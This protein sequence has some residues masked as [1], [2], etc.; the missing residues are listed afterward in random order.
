MADYATAEQVGELAHEFTPSSSLSASLVT[1]A[2]RMFDN[3]TGVSDDFFAA[4]ADPAEY[5]IR[6]YYGNGTG[7]LVVDPYTALN[8]TDPIVIDPDYSY[9]I[10]AYTERD[11]M[12]VRYGSYVSRLI[13]W[14]DGVRVSVSANWGFTA[15]PA[16]VTQ[17]TAGLAIHLFRTTDPA[18]ATISAAENVELPAYVQTIIDTYKAKYTKEMAFA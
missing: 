5:S 14:D 3:L 1:R 4:A 18:F 2:S 12:L 17:A 9:E 13:G 11:G 16:P 8:P 6:N 7:Y 10:P 15:V